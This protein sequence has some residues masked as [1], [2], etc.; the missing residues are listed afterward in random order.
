MDTVPWVV[1]CE[2]IS[3]IAIKCV[4]RQVIKSARQ[5]LLAEVTKWRQ[6]LVQAI[7]VSLLKS[8]FLLQITSNCDM[9]LRQ[10]LVYTVSCIN[11]PIPNTHWIS[12]VIKCIL[13][14]SKILLSASISQMSTLWYGIVVPHID[15]IRWT[16]SEKMGRS[17]QETHAVVSKLTKKLPGITHTCVMK[18]IL[19]YVVSVY[20]MEITISMHVLQWSR[21]ITSITEW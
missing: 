21:I 3:L 6:V 18:E 7:T 20:K 14:S 9:F 10:T 17:N 13:T 19:N 5:I 12:V 8:F 1:E 11:R 15:S 16:L 2:K 4:N